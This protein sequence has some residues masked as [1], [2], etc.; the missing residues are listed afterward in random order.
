MTTGERIRTLRLSR[1]FPQGVFADMV[2][3]KKQTL[4]KYE[5]NVVENIPLSTL[6]TMAAALGVTPGYL[7]DGNVDRQAEAAWV[8]VFRERLSSVLAMADPADIEASNIDMSRINRCL[9][10][11][12]ILL[13]DAYDIANEVGEDFLYLCGI[14]DEKEPTS[15][16]GG[17]LTETERLLMSY[18]AKLNRDQQQMLLAQLNALREAQKKERVP[19]PDD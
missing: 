2:G 8:V 7:L 3:I 15:K 4:Y 14:T 11:F 10:G 5:N 18:V 9:N 17:G 19:S 12:P 1:E 13:E 6:R 16:S